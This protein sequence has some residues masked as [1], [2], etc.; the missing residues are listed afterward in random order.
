MNPSPAGQPGPAL[1]S[2]VN[3]F[4]RG[5]WRR[6]QTAAEQ[7]VRE[8]PKDPRGYIV[9]G[10]V[11]YQYGAFDEAAEHL[12]QA[13][14]LDPKSVAARTNL[15]FVR[16][17]QDR[18]VEASSCFDRALKLDPTHFGALTGKVEGLIARGRYDQA[19]RV[20]E[21]AKSRGM[22]D[23][24]ELAVLRGTIALHEKDPA[25]ALAA[26][27]PFAAR[28]DLEPLDAYRL[29]LT[30]G[31]ALEQQEEYDAAFAAFETGNNA[32]AAPNS[33]RYI[34]DRVDAL[35]RVFPGDQPLA[36]S[37]CD[38]ELPIFIVSMPRTGSTLIEQILHAHPS[39]AG[40]GECTVVVRATESIPARFG[41]E[42]PYPDSLAE[43]SKDDLSALA[44]T[45]LTE[46]RQLAGRA[47][48]VVDKNLLNYLNLGFLAMTLPRAKVIYCRRDPV[49]TCLSCYTEMLDPALHPYA[50]DLSELGRTYRE[51]ER[52]MRHWIDH[53]H[54]DFLEVEYEELVREPEPV[55]RRLIEFVGLP[56]DD[57]CLRPHEA[58]RMITTLSH[59]QVRQPVYRSS[60]GRSE[61]FAPHLR[62]LRES[63]EEHG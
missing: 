62:P 10:Q 33:A 1:V 22:P 44:E 8:A 29:Q 19:R 30:R 9:L 46:Y 41:I 24:P 18:H 35:V 51:C 34:A 38:S 31:K 12:Q 7:Y 40:G 61:R 60:I 54:F 3:A 36:T 23:A 49:D 5:Q 20:L 55:S 25:A 47:E 59:S 2:A 45:M 27:K 63:L 4:N 56:W 52:L 57:R 17:R 43:L 37:G 26:T 39:I 50:T 21:R 58:K 13:I 15:G 42:R 14:R 6:A 16:T 28:T 32:V 48:R 53:L 11:A